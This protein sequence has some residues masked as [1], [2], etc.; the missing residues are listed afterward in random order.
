[1]NSGHGTA[2]L[3]GR[4]VQLLRSGRPGWLSML[5]RPSA[6]GVAGELLAASAPGYAS[7]FLLGIVSGLGVAPCAFG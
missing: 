4:T 7:L 5:A 2:D 1:M 3:I 6:A